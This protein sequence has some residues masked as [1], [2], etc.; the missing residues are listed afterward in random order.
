MNWIN[1]LKQD[2]KIKLI[3]MQKENICFVLIPKNAHLSMQYTLENQGFKRGFI[4]NISGKMKYSAIIRDPVSKWATGFATYLTNCV[5]NKVI[6]E[7]NAYKIFN[8]WGC[9]DYIFKIIEFDIHTVKQRSIINQF[10][11][12]DIKLFDIK[13]LDPLIKYFNENGVNI[14]GIDTAHITENFDHEGFHYKIYKIIN[15]FLFSHQAYC[16]LIKQYYSND[17]KLYKG[18][19]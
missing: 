17:L 18:L 2:L 19:Q 10:V 8:S 4:K 16:D 12:Q 14:T 15:E 13:N 9:I 6:T 11:N 5:N 3:G 1:K 7:Y